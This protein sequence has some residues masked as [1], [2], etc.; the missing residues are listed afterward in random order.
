M[1]LIS[2]VDS[3]NTKSEWWHRALVT[4]NDKWWEGHSL[5]YLV[6]EVVP[7]VDTHLWPHFL[8]H[9]PLSELTLS[10]VDNTPLLNVDTLT[11]QFVANR[12]GM[13]IYCYFTI[14][15]SARVNCE[16]PHMQGWAC[17]WPCCLDLQGWLTNDIWA[18]L[19]TVSSCSRSLCCVCVLGYISV[20]ERL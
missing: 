4:H 7:T 12:P 14:P 10:F 18:D 9:F 16:S 2:M 1:C 20:G 15:G 5:L 6:S 17:H 3:L 19:W 8:F 13:E 11:A